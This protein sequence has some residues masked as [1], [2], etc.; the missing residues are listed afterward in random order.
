M[1]ADT[2]ATL[3]EATKLWSVE[4]MRERTSVVTM[5]AGAFAVGVGPGRAGA[6]PLAQAPNANPAASTWRH[7]TRRPVGPTWAALVVMRRLPRAGVPKYAPGGSAS[8]AGFHE[9][10]TPTARG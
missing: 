3:P 2:P 8:E 4:S 10:T 1:S 6:A 7:D 5:R 9:A